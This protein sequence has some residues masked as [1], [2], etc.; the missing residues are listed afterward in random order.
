MSLALNSH[1]SRSNGEF[2]PGFIAHLLSG[3]ATEDDIFEVI[4][5]TGCTYAISPHRDDFVKRALLDKNMTSVMTVNGPTSVAGVGIARWVFLCENGQEVE[6]LIKFHHVPGSKV[7]LLSPQ[8]YC[9][10]HGFNGAEYQ[11][12]CRKLLLFLDER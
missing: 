1:L 6:L 8:D 4:L 10:F 11:A 9:Q 3:F 5:D 2:D 12:V 7:R